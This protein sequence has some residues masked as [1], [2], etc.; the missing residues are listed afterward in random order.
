MDIVLSSIP[1]VLSTGTMVIVARRYAI[2]V[3]VLW[4]SLLFLSWL[5]FNIA[6][7]LGFSISFDSHISLIVAV[8]GIIWLSLFIAMLMRRHNISIIFS[9]ILIVVYGVAASHTYHSEIEGVLSSTV[10]ALLNAMPSVWAMTTASYSFSM[11]LL[12]AAASARARRKDEAATSTASVSEIPA[13]SMRGNSRHRLHIDPMHDVSAIRRSQVNERTR[14]HHPPPPTMMRTVSNIFL[15]K[16]RRH[17]ENK[18]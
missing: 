7:V 1:M 4:C 6:G 2:R 8:L 17:G 16:M 10:V 3:S 15:N 5:A 11:S 12:V 18:V 9:V 13:T 14:P